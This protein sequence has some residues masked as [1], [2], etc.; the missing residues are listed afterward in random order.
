ML[1]RKKLGPLQL[2]KQALI[3]ESS[4]NRLALQAEWQ[5]LRQAGRRLTNPAQTFGN[6]NPWLLLLAPVAGFLAVRSLRGQE[7]ML[8][9]ATALLK[10]AVPLYRLWTRFRAKSP[11]QSETEADSP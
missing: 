5:N 11:D 3:L 4:L 1:G 10:W 8:S 6:A 9:R 7:S 2:Q